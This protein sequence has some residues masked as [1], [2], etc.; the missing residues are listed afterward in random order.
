[1]P[2]TRHYYQVQYFDAETTE[3]EDIRDAYS[4]QRADAI[5]Y[6]EQRFKDYPKEPIRVVFRT[7]T[8]VQSFGPDPRT[9]LDNLRNAT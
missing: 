6:A 1:M 7:E 8:D 3:Y 5:E 4:T 9:F 2:T